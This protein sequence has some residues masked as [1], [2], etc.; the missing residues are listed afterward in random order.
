[1]GRQACDRPPKGVTGRLNCGIALGASDRW[2]PIA[3]PLETVD[4]LKPL[5]RFPPRGFRWAGNCRDKPE[6]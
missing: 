4:R 2:S 3:K 6:F 1:M 5:S